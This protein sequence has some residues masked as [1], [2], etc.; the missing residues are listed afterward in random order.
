[1]DDVMKS[2]AASAAKLNAACDAMAERVRAVET[3]L[4]DNG[5]GVPC[6]VGGD[7]I[8]LGYGRVG[9]KFRVYFAT[10]GGRVPWSDASRA[11]KIESFPLLPDL[12]AAV[13]KSLGEATETVEKL[14]DRTNH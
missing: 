5:V 9:A 2:I 14:L 1:M 11:S 10:E 4:T 12:L 7:G 8:R 6:E 13:A 3:F